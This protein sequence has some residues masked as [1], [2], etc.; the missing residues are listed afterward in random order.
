MNLKAR[1]DVHLARR[2][3]HFV[4]VM[5]AFTAYSFLNE[6]QA[7]VVAVCVTLPLVAFDIAR[8]YSARLNNTFLTC[9]R[10]ILRD[11]ERNKLAGSTAMLIGTTAIIFLFPRDVVLSTMLFFAVADPAASYFG[12]RYGRDK[13]IG[14]KSLQGTMAAF[15]ACF[16]LA[17]LYFYARDLMRERLFIVCLLAAFAGAVSELIPVGRLDDNFIFPVLNATFLTAIFYVFGGF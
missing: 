6:A 2:I 12:V 10:P 13:L 14:N 1:N 4:G 17:L 9:F 11:S 7:R 16:F 15:F 3:W 5:V 8:L